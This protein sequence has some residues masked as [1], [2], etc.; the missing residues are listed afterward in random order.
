LGECKENGPVALI[1]IESGNDV[2]GGGDL[3]RV[4]HG[5][6]DGLDGFDGLD[7][8]DGLDGLDFLDF[9]DGDGNDFLDLNLDFRNWN[10]SGSSSTTLGNWNVFAVLAFGVAIGKSTRPDVFATGRR[11]RRRWRRR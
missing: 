9:L 8:L 1:L 5:S 7:F 10:G 4:S 11:R 2:L 6:L 3:V